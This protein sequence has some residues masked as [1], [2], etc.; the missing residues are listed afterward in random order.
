M[1]RTVEELCRCGFSQE[2]F[3]D[4]DVTAGFQCFD[5]SPSAVTFRAV[6]MDLPLASSSQLISYIEEWVA[7]QPSIVVLSSRLSI[8]S[9]CAVEI[10]NFNAPE[11]NDMTPSTSDGNNNTNTNPNSVA[12]P[13]IGGVVGGI[14]VLLLAIVAL[15]LVV[16]FV[17]N[18][19]KKST[20]K[21]NVH[22]EDIDIYE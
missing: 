6:I 10:D 5:A 22:K 8:D 1:T 11:C 17:R 4:I 21:L 2:A 20:Y 16:I 19:Q 14:C 9:S 12:G 13:V 3:Q 7:T 18:C 15:V